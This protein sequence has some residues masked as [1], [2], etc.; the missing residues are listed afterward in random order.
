VARLAVDLA[1]EAAGT[2]GHDARTTHVGYYLVDEG[3]ARLE[4]S[5][6]ARFS[7]LASL[8][9]ASLRHPLALYLGSVAVLTL[10]PAAAL[11]VRARREGADGSLP[12]AARRRPAAGAPSQVA[13]AAVMPWCPGWRRPA[14]CRRWTSRQASRQPLARWFVV[15]TLITSTQAVEQMVEALEVR[16]LG[17]RDDHVAFGLLTDLADAS[18]ES[19]PED[20]ALERLAGQR[21][22]ELNDKYGPA[23]LPLPPAAALESGEQVWMGYERKRGKLADLNALLRG[24]ANGRFSTI[25]GDTSI[26]RR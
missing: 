16:F 18:A 23:F 8:S 21:I 22:G 15:P 12:R 13:V 6:R 3:R 10:L 5:A 7:V 19:L 1:R 9:R 26:L 24:R 14:P 20:E 17:N 25:V 11:I 4:R 2:S